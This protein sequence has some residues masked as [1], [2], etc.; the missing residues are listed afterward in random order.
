MEKRYC[1][2][3]DLGA[4]LEFP[5]KD[6]GRG[7]R[8]KTDYAKAVRKERIAKELYG[9]WFNNLHAYSKGKI[10]CSCAMC[11]AKTNRH[12]RSS[13]LTVGTL[14]RLGTKNYAYSD[15]KKLSGF[16]FEQEE[17]QRDC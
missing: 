10:H 3:E 16:L 6:L 11:A 9:T 12:A 5:R 8:R 15:Q 14:H 4:E 2:A 1:E 13:R 17:Y 7:K